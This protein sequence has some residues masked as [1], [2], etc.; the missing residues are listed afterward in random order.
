MWQ[1]FFVYTFVN[2]GFNFVVLNSLS[3]VDFLLLNFL[4]HQKSVASWI[5][6]IIAFPNQNIS[7][8]YFSNKYVPFIFID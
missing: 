1:I 7:T 5:K 6:E 3:I 2:H 4:Q 8:Y